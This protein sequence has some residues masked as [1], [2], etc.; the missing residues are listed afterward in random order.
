MTKILAT[1]AL[2]VFF[3]TGVMAST[4]GTL[5]L[6]GTVP[7][8]L[9]IEVTPE[10][11][12]S[13]LPLDTT[14][15]ETKVA[16]IN[17]VSNSNTGYS[18]AISS[19]NQGALVHETETSSAINYTLRYDGNTVDLASG[20]SYSFPSAGSVDANKDV[21]ISYTGVDHA[22]LIEGDYGDTVTFTI[23]AN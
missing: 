7:Q 22:Q 8:L 14:Q 2:T 13:N 15:T 17:E 10:P 21:D 18:V 23:S 9:S 19:D 20:D 11:I 16:T 5:I 6:N 1:L 3:T 12:A 4:T